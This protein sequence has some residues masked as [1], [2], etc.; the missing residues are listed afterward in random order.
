LAETFIRNVIVQAVE[1]GFMRGLPT[2]FGSEKLVSP[3]MT[4]EKL[5]QIA[6]DNPKSRQSRRELN[7]RTMKV[8]ETYSKIDSILGKFEN[9]AV[10]TQWI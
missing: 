4:N 5:R 9:S 3:E 1:R 2:I 6:G 8:K 7:E 10:S